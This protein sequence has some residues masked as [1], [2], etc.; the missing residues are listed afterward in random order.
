MTSVKENSPSLQ[1]KKR[2]FLTK[3]L[4]LCMK[5]KKIIFLQLNKLSR[6]KKKEKEKATKISESEQILPNERGKKCFFFSY[7]SYKT[8]FSK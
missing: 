1:G 6:K 7:R 4:I 3:L 8:Y 5:K 2:K